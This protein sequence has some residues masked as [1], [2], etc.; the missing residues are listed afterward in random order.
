MAMPG[1]PGVSLAQREAGDKACSVCI[2]RELQPHSTG[3]VLTTGEAVILF[4]SERPGRVSAARS[5]SCHE[6]KIVLDE[7]AS[8]RS[9]IFK[10]HKKRWKA[11]EA[12]APHNL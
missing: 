5:F 3:V 6:R 4:R 7:H 12:S 1:R 2:E 11:G 10:Y 9:R 8:E